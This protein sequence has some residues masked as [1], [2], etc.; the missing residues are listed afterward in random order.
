M[1]AREH[2]ASFPCTYVRTC[3][4]CGGALLGPLRLYAC[5]R[6]CVRSSSRSSSQEAYELDRL[7]N[8]R[9][10][11]LSIMEEKF[12]AKQ[13]MELQAG[14]PYS[15]SPNP[16]LRPAAWVGRA[17]PR[18]GAHKPSSPND[19]PR[20]HKPSHSVALV[21]AAGSPQAHADGAR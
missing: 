10:M 13:S 15:L 9:Q 12:L 19:L 11:R 2:V 4:C 5:V 14:L 16:R 1:C 3:L 21:G 20:L 17:A 18:I 8:Q 6:A 7:R